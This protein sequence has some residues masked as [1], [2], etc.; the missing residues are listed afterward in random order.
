[1]ADFDEFEVCRTKVKNFRT[2]VPSEDRK[3]QTARTEFA[4]IKGREL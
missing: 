2:V 1:M 4:A 3:W